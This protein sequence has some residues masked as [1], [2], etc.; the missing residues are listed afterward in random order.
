MSFQ[1]ASTKYI[2]NYDAFFN[3]FLYFAWFASLAIIVIA[4][5]TIKKDFG[6]FNNSELLLILP[7][8]LYA[9]KINNYI[10]VIEIVVVLIM[11]FGKEKIRSL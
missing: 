10:V 7:F 9:N 11:F 1:I 8:M 6:Y 3:F 4:Y 5:K 2:R